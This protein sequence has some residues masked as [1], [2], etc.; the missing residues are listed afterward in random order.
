M[1]DPLNRLLRAAIRHVK[2]SALSMDELRMRAKSGRELAFA[3]VLEAVLRRYDNAL[4]REGACDFEDLINIARDQIRGGAWKPG[5]RYVLVDEFQ[6]ISRGRMELVAALQRRGVAYFLVGDDWQSIYRFAG[7]DVGIVKDCG[8]W[9]GHVK[10]LEIANVFRYGHRI[11]GPTSAFVVRNP[12]QINRKLQTRGSEPD[13]GITV[14]S[15]TSRELGI[16]AAI[17]DIL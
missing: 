3:D 11:L 14:V 2:N 5:Y 13:L 16:E 15:D 4:E 9:L 8:R 7:S 6:D 17:G 1:L 12:E 10:R